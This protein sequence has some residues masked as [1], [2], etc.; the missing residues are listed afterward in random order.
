MLGNIKIVVVSF[1]IPLFF[2]ELI[3]RIQILTQYNHCLV[4]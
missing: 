1:D 4:N 3:M 2:I